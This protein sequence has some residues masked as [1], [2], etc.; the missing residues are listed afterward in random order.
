VTDWSY[1]I[2]PPQGEDEPELEAEP[3]PFADLQSLSW[4]A[5]SHQQLEEVLAFKVCGRGNH[6]RV[7]L[8]ARREAMTMTKTVFHSVLDLLAEARR[9][10]G[11]AELHVQAHECSSDTMATHDGRLDG[12]L[13]ELEERAGV[14]A[15]Q[16]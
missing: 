15:V 14:V 16:S 4:R 7:F 6:W 8:A 12:L 3:H 1:R 10:L 9:M 5:H 11:C 2:D 13:A